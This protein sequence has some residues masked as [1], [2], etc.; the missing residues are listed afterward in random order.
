[1]EINKGE[2]KTKRHF[3]TIIIIDMYYSLVF[4]CVLNLY[5]VNNTLLVQGTFTNYISLL[6]RPTQTNHGNLYT[7]FTIRIF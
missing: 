3:P 4:D 2:N 5:L 7:S 1:M 6:W